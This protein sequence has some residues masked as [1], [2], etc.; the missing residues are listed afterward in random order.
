MTAQHIVKTASWLVGLYD[1]TIQG[2]TPCSNTNG[3]YQTNYKG[4][5]AYCFLV[6]FESN[7][8]CCFIFMFLL[9]K[10]LMPHNFIFTV[11]QGPKISSFWNQ[12]LVCMQDISSL[13]PSEWSCISMVQILLLSPMINIQFLTRYFLW[14]AYYTGI[15]VKALLLLVLQL[16]AS[17]ITSV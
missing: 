5:C 10:Y 8:D 12:R 1:S 4:I 2:T 9:V 13:P 11:V 17:I 7:F 14:W 3:C 15:V 6:C 16:F